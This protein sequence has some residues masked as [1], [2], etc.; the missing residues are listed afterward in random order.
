MAST[1]YSLPPLNTILIT[2]G[3]THYHRRKSVI[4]L[5]VPEFWLISSRM[6]EKSVFDDDNIMDIGSD[7]KDGKFYVGDGKSFPLIH[8]G[9]T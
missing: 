9:S 3:T 6:H 8:P 4:Y 7:L 1:E 2:T 5:N